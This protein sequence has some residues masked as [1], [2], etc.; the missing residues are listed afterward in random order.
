VDPRAHAEYVRGRY[1][2]NKRTGEGYRRA[3]EHFQRALDIDPAYARA[4]AGLADC[5]LLLTDV[6]R[7]PSVPLAKA[8]A[9]ARKALEIDSALVEAHTSLA[10]TLMKQWHWAESISIARTS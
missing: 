2:W 6:D 1:Y 3:L 4:Y 7:D 10:M 8:A 9:A 5:Y